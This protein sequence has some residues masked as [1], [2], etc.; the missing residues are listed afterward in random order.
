MKRLISILIIFSFMLIGITTTTYA[1]DWKSLNVELISQTENDSQTILTLKD[2]QERT[3]KVIYQDETMLAKLATTIIK[4]KNEFYTWRSIRF[5]DISFMVFANFLNV[6]IIPQQLPHNNLNLAMAIPGG[7]VMVYDPEKDTVHYDFRIMKE[8]QFVRIDGDYLKEDQLVSKIGTAYDNPSGNLQQP[9][10][11]VSFQQENIG[12]D[13]EKILQSLIYLYN[14]DWNGRHKSIPI[15]TIQ[16]VIEL[17]QNNPGMTKKQLWKMVKKEK[18]QITNR[19]LNLIL[20]VYF[21]EFDQN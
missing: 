2:K 5:K 9:T 16:K 11:P 17:R 18:I 13:R 10:G 7:I 12:S 14:E 4:Y 19:E 8:D 6:V 1:F 21:N 15:D 20:I 3:F